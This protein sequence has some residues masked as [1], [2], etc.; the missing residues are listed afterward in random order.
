VVQS[1]D[2][3]LTFFEQEALAFSRFLPYF[4]LPGRLA[5]A[6]SSDSFIT[7]TAGLELVAYKYSNLAAA[8]ANKEQ[9]QQQ[10][11]CCRIH[12]TAG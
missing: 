5:Y 3:Q 10:G 1:Y 6:A 11:T 4:L 2:G 9:Q 12:V 7:S 8:S